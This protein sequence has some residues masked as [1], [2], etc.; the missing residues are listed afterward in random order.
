MV[1][2]Y[3]HLLTLIVISIILLNQNN[4][5]IDYFLGSLILIELIFLLIFFLKKGEIYQLKKMIRLKD[6]FVRSH[7]YLPFETKPNFLIKNDIHIQDQKNK[8]FLTPKYLKTN[9]YGYS[10]G[11]K[12]DRE[13]AKSDKIKVCCLGASTTGNYLFFENENISYPIIL[14]QEIKKKL[15][16]KIEVN[17]FGQGG[18]NSQELLISFLT[19]IIFTKPD[20]LILYHGHNDIRSYLANNFKLDYSN[21]RVNIL[22]NIWKL[23]ILSY[24]SFI[25]L[26]FVNKIIDKFSLQNSLLDFITNNEMNLNNK[27]NKGLEVYQKNIECIVDIC[28]QRKIKV[29]LSTY[30]YKKNK[31]KLSKKIKTIIDKENKIMKKIA[32]NKKVFFIDNNKLIKK[33]DINF[34]D[35]VHFTPEGM[36]NIA[37]NFMPFVLKCV[38]EL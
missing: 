16:K 38:K 2:K 4:I 24:L 14:E 20:I 21:S 25:P 27:A 35:S 8:K 11:K 6:L 13:P 30:C 33:D 5:L 31:S 36:K 15:K 1:K 19:K 17:N 7:P 34:L 12:G 29:I 18:Y 28:L 37:R 32:K 23:R 22:K 9:S 26:G 10:D 3:F